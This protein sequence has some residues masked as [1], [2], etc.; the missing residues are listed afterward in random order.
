M[1]LKAKVISKYIIDA[2]LETVAPRHCEVCGDYI[3]TD[4]RQFEFIC[5]SCV[6]QFPVAPLPSE[7]Y[8]RLVSNFDRN[9]LA[10]DNAIALMSLSENDKFI[11]IIYSLKYNGFRRVGIE[12]GKE[13]GRFLLKY[14]M[15]S[16][17]ALV[18]VPIHSARRRERGFNQSELI[19]KGINS[20]INVPVDSKLIKRTRYT[21]SQTLLNKEERKSNISN[22]FSS[23]KKTNEISGKSFL[24]V[25]DVLTTGSTIN[26]IGQVLKQI[27]AKRVD[28]ASLAIA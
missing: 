9:E 5:D 8:N 28:C 22:V 26:A 25:D 24:L 6:A 19:S 20:I 16:Y 15:I 11:N 14:N 3:G 7:V 23:Y 18:P 13:L 4:I 2:I 12:F 27:G 21:Q 1:L 17:D 10:I